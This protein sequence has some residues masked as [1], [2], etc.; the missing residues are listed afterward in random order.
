MDLI[1]QL[2]GIHLALQSQ[3]LF[4]KFSVKYD[5]QSNRMHAIKLQ[6]LLKQRQ[7]KANTVSF[8]SM[9]QYALYPLS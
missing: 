5:A 4:L 8:P 2:K 9:H 1:R 6:L 7:Q 3:Q